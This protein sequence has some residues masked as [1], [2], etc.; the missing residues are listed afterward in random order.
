MYV[1]GDVTGC[2]EYGSYDSGKYIEVSTGDVVHITYDGEWRTTHHVKSGKVDVTHH[3]CEEDSD[4]YTDRMTLTGDIEWVR[5]W[6]NWPYHIS[7][8]REKVITWVEN[9]EAR[10]ISKEAFEK[11][12]HVLW[13]ERLI[14]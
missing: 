10:K 6:D 11:L 2:D 5:V 7:G 3:V 12:F 9:F 4:D 13:Q 1:D 14:K 8:M